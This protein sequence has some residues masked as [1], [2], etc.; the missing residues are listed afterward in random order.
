MFSQSEVVLHSNLQI[1]KKKTKN[2]LDNSWQIQTIGSIFRW[3]KSLSQH[4][5]AFEN[6]VKK[7]LRA[8]SVTK[9]EMNKYMAEIYDPGGIRTRAAIDKP[10]P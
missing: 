1:L 10:I 2:A 9:K 6:I 3:T 4:P 8:K 5:E 7:F